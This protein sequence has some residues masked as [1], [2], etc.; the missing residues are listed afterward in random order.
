MTSD[1]DGVKTT[2]T[3]TFSSILSNAITLVLAVAAMYQKN[4]LLATIGLLIVPLFTIPTRRA[5]KMRWKLT[6]QPEL[7]R[8]DQ[9]HPERDALR[10]RADALQA[11]LPRTAGVRPL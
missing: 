10:Q 3:N 11:L 1:I 4:W 9:R 6:Q 7:Q 8:R 2:I 5:G